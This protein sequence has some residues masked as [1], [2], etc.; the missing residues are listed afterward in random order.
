MTR[1]FPRVS[2]VLAATAA[3]SMVATPAMA[4]GGGWGGRHYHRHHD[5]IDGGDV[6][7]GLLIIGGIAAIASAASKADKERREREYRYPD[8]ND[9][10]AS[11]G[12]GDPAPDRG[13]SRDHDGTGR[14]GPDGISAAVD[15]CAN[16]VERG[17][18][19]I[20]SIESV[21]REGE[22]W[23]VEGRVNG[24]RDFACSVSDSGRIRSVTV[25]GQAA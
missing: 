11:R 2:A 17:D 18:R 24:G 4:R 19:G 8:N 9:R 25:D 20:D 10:E 21:E 1:Y 5:G 3:L 16:E 23:R 22:G 7:A 12:Y 13:S 15:A 6:L 14:A